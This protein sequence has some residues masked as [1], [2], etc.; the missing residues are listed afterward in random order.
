[1][2]CRFDQTI[3]WQIIVSSFS[4][5]HGIREILELQATAVE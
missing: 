2:L 5:Y 1:M 3:V 4:R